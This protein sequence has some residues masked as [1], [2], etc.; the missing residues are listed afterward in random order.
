MKKYCAFALVFA[1][2]ILSPL[3]SGSS[4]TTVVNAQASYDVTLDGMVDGSDLGIVLA[5]WGPCNNSAPCPA[6]VNSDGTVDT[7][8]VDLIKA[9]WS[10]DT[11]RSDQDVATRSNPDLNSDGMVDGQDLGIILS[12]QGRCQANATSSIR[13]SMTSC[14]SDLNGDGIVGKADVDILLKAWSGKA[15]PKLSSEQ[16][17]R[18]RVLAPTIPNTLRTESVE[19]RRL[20]Q[21][22]KDNVS[23]I[24][25]SINLRMRVAV[26]RLESISERLR[27]RMDKLAANGSNV[28][29]ARASLSNANVEIKAASDLV[30]ANINAGTSTSIRENAAEI[31]KHLESARASLVEALSGITTPTTTS[32]PSA[33]VEVNAN[34]G[35][36][37]PT[38]IQAI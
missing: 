5:S 22:R 16:K 27:V 14:K 35:S 18:L 2:M 26:S 10:E 12:A 38:P 37:M 9:N 30:Q 6:D 8:D 23:S 20:V 34:S 33:G 4:F 7:A 19:E 36:V 13:G 1:F 32:A 31:K 24:V 25:A 11:T 3:F 17:T 28:T 15:D 21:E 29:Q